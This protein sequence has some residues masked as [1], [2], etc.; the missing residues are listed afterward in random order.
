MKRG[1]WRKWLTQ[2][3]FDNLER[4]VNAKKDMRTPYYIQVQLNQNYGGPAAANAGLDAEDV[5]FTNV[6][7]VYGI[8]MVCMNERPII[9]QLS[10]MLF[11][12]DNVR[13]LVKMVYA[14]PAD[15]PNEVEDSDNYGPVV[16]T[17][18]ENARIMGMPLIWN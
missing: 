12:V 16:P 13:G 1:D 18:Y 9:P 17:V 8:R 4:V 2:E 11:Y 15:K 10:T 6:K 7:H 3:L 14:M 5:T